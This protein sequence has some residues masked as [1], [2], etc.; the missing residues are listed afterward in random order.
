M[1][2]EF[3]AVT[4]PSGRT[5]A[6]SRASRSAVSAA[7][8]RSSSSTPA[9]RHQL[10]VER[11]RA[12]GPPTRQRV[13]PG[14]VRV[15]P[16]PGDARAPA[17]GVGGRTHL[18]IGDTGGAN[19]P[20]NRRRA[21][22]AAAT[23]RSALSDPPASTSRPRRRG[24]GPRPSRTASRPLPHCRSTVSPGTSTPEAGGAARRPGP[25]RR[26]DRCSCR[27]P[28][29][30]RRAASGPRGH[31]PAPAAPVRP[32]RST[33]HAGEGPA[34][35]RHGR[36]PGGDHD[37]GC[38]GSIG[39][40]SRRWQAWRAQRRGRGVSAAVARSA[41]GRPPGPACRR[42]AGEVAHQPPAARARPLGRP[43]QSRR[44]GPGRPGRG[45]AVPRP[46]TTATSRSPSRG[47]G[48]R[49]H[50]TSSTAPR[51][52]PDHRLHV[53]DHHRA[54]AG[55]DR[56][57]AAAAHAQPVRSSQPRSPTVAQ[58]PVPPQRAA[59]RRRR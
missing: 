33:V 47:C 39:R 45:V 30:R 24:P 49:R 2:Q 46:A 36:T 16:F 1:P 48:S 13:R 53:L 22:R 15:L 59:V 25:G 21:S 3:P 40:R 35:R 43:A 19:G 34:G 17:S 57:V 41:P 4:V 8:G 55:G 51:A 20:A 29:R 28:R 27:A 50:A 6:G 23:A 32:G 9:D 42:R 12:R 38:P 56:R 5:P 18:G 10:R 37:R 26:R 31:R 58:P 11:C 44:G 7:R 14:G 54:A 52:V